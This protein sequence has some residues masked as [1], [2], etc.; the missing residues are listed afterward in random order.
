MSNENQNQNDKMPNDAGVED[1]VAEMCEEANA[2]CC[3]GCDNDTGEV[4]VEDQLTKA[5]ADMAEMKEQMMREQA[6]T[7]NIRK[8]LQ[9]DV[10]QA[11]KFALERF[12]NDLL[13]VVDNLERAIQSASNDE[14]MKPMLEGIELTY[15]SFLD[16]LKK[17]NVEQLNPL[18]QP[19]NPEFHEAVAMVPNPAAEPN[20]VMDVM[21][22]GYMLNER[23]LRAAM[24]AVVKG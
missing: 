15:K 4:L 10:E 3:G 9:R 13:P 20:T 22:K 19:F 2:A 16:V 7:Q 11:R 1:A 12:I 24:V 17:N 23:L 6:E 14:A 8:R 5:L 21:Q 18:G